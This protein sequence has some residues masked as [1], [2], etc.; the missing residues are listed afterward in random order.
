MKM[1]GKGI[2]ALAFAVALGSSA[3]AAVVTVTAGAPGYL[4]PANAIGFE[5]VG[6]GNITAAGFTR[7]G[8]SFSNIGSVPLA[9]T[10]QGSNG[11]GAN[12]AGFPSGNTYVSVLLNG[13]LQVSFGLTNS[14]SLFWGSIDPSNEI[15]FYN[16]NTQVGQLF[17]SGVTPQLT[18][19]GN[20]VS[21]N[22]NRFVTLSDTDAFNRVVITS[23][24]NSFELD[25][26]VAPAVPEPATWAMMMLGF[27]GLGFMGYRKRSKTGGASF[28]LA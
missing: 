24:Q 16:G 13:L 4:G 26:F 8:V 3:H 11:N 27:L 19:D 18:A 28:R 9:I 1:I 21:D 23:G 15:T 10:Q 5:D 14:I 12:P 2:A 6:T 22:S 7:S 20:Q 17:G 25:S